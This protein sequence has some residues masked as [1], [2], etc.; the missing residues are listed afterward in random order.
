[1]YETSPRPGT[2]RTTGSAARLTGRRARETIEQPV[3]PGA[4]AVVRHRQ[5]NPRVA[6]ELDAAIVVIR[7]KHDPRILRRDVAGVLVALFVL[8]IASQDGFGP[9]G[10]GPSVFTFRPVTKMGLKPCAVR[11][12]GRHYEGSRRQGSRRWRPA[13]DSNARSSPSGRG[14]GLN[15]VDATLVGGGLPYHPIAQ[16]QAPGLP[17]DDGELGT[18][19]SADSRGGDG[20][21]EARGAKRTWP[22]QR[23]PA[24]P[25][26]DRPSGSRQFV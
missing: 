16:P 18:K 8:R 9:A 24:W 11:G 10:T 25:S 15:R 1:M 22:R 23:R 17:A 20:K 14:A 2:V 19:V 26:A 5:A 6:E 7:A 21:Q 3:P 13:P 4:A 12:N